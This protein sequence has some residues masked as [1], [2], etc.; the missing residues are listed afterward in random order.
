MAAWEGFSAV[1]AVKN[2]GVALASMFGG[3]YLAYRRLKKDKQSDTVVDAS[4]DATKK[5]LQS[6]TEQ[7]AD[8]LSRADTE[9]DRANAATDLLQGALVRSAKLE[10]SVEHLT[11]VVDRLE[12]AMTKLQKTN[13]VLIAFNRDLLASNESLAGQVQALMSTVKSQ[14]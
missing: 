11:T 1:E 6:L 10:V 8:A 12:G 4:S 5:L 14:G 7:R 2:L 9:R 13:D 3:G